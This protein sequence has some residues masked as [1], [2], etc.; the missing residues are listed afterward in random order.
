LK[1]FDKDFIFGTLYK[2]EYLSK[3]DNL[4]IVRLIFNMDEAVNDTK[5]KASFELVNGENRPL[6]SEK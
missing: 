3:L 6:L 4:V 1:F 5:V 2:K